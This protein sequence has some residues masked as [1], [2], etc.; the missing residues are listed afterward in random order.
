MAPRAELRLGGGLGASDGAPQGAVLRGWHCKWSIRSR[1][2]LVGFRWTRWVG[3]SQAGGLRALPVVT[4]LLEFN[5]D[6]F[7]CTNPDC[8]SPRLVTGQEL[9]AGVIMVTS[10]IWVT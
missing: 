9:T 2:P 1:V 5:P 8:R 7:R 10:T 3:H 6:L 4:Q